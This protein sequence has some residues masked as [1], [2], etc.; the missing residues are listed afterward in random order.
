MKRES[1]E[2][3]RQSHLSHGHCPSSLDPSK[4]QP[5][6]EYIIWGLMRQ[7]C[8]NP[9]AT[10]YH[11]YGGRGIKVCERWDSFENFWADMG[12]RPSPRHTIE[13]SDN[14]GNYEPGNCRWATYADQSRNKRNNRNLTLNG[15]TL[16]LN[17]WANKT[18][19]TSRAIGRRLSLGWSIESAL[20]AALH[21]TATIEWRGESRTLSEWAKV[22]G[23]NST[24]LRS[25]LNGGWGIE[26]ALTT[27]A[28]QL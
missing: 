13:R 12:P 10:G 20:T 2:K 3:S 14:D 17:D 8:R 22:T 5:S 19:L 24:T 15:E 28:I 6:R 9:K 7:R 4:K 26:A 23:I 21:K 11:R 27:P 25:R 18:G 16:C 1:R